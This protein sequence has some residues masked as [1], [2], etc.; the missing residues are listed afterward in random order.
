MIAL[1]G[2]R[3]TMPSIKRL[4]QWCAF[5]L[6]A[7]GLALAQQHVLV[8][9]EGTSAVG[10]ESQLGRVLTYICPSKLNTNREIWGTDIYMYESPICTA[11][12]HAG[13]FTPGASGQVTIVIG[14]GAKSFD[15]KER[16]VVKSSSY[17]PRHSTY[18]FI[19]NGEPGQIEW[20]TTLERIPDDFHAPLT[21]LCPPKGNADSYVWGTDV[22]TSSSAICVAAVHAGVIT[23]D[24]GGKV[25]VAFQPKQETFIGSERNKIL[26]S[27]WTNW[28]FQSYSQPYKLSAD[29]SDPSGGGPRTIR[30]TG[31]TA[32]GSAP[33]IVPRIIPLK[34]FEATGTAPLIVPRSIP[35]KGWTGMGIAKQNLRR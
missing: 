21:L 10:Y 4:I 32:A 29:D 2:I 6:L 24:A 17:G 27:D 26:S 7:P 15:G 12:V 33:I 11:A 5:L 13:V 23:L 16:N 3:M 28:D 34:G 1:A 19:K 9:D 22:Y 30:L 18:S 20:Y 14:P 31:F 8:A 35:L 25:T